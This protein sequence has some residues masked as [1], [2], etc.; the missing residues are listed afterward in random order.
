[1]IS[2]RLLSSNVIILS[3]KDGTNGPKDFECHATKHK[4]GKPQLSDSEEAETGYMGGV[5]LRQGFMCKK[6]RQ[7]T[8]HDP[9]QANVSPLK[10]GYPSKRERVL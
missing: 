10:Q 1:M 5:R 8:L 7:V 3:E 2:T 4:E 9:H 6:N